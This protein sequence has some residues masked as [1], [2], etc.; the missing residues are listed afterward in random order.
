MPED[1]DEPEAVSEEAWRR[2]KKRLC[3]NSKL[4]A[5]ETV[6]LLQKRRRTEG[7]SDGSGAQSAGAPPE[8][9][10]DPAGPEVRPPTKKKVALAGA[11]AATTCTTSRTWR[12]H[13]WWSP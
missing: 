4:M 3:Q 6:E 9:G 7:L 10:A 1:K 5:R 2:Y 11:L 12:T 13:S 8:G